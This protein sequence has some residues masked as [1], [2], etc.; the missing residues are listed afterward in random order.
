M[1]TPVDKN[2]PEL[3]EG[4]ALGPYRIEEIIFLEE[5]DAHLYKLIH[6]PTG[7]AH[8]HISHADTEN[9]FSVGFKTVPADST[10]V[11]HILEHTVLCGSKKYPVR[12]PFFSMLK[13]SLNTFMNAFTASDWTMYPFSTQNKKDFYN[14]MDVYLDA[15]FFPRLDELS[16]KQEGHR[17]EIA[18]DG[19]AGDFSLDYKGVVYN[20]MK[21]AMSSPYQVMTRSL[22][23]A[24][25]PDTT[26]RHNSGGDPAQ[27]VHLTHS[28]LKDFHQRHYHPSNARF[29]TYG[30]F[31]LEDHLRVIH[32]KALTDFEKINPDTDV[33]AQ[34]RWDRE[35]E[36]I[37]AYPLSKTENPEKK[38]QV[39]MAW[40]TADILDA[41]E[42]LSLVLLEQILL[43][44][45]AS[46]LRK[47]LIDSG[48]GTALSDASGY[49]R[50]NRDTMFACG[51][52]DT[53]KS[54]A[55]DINALIFKTLEHL[56]ANGI[57]KELIDSAIHQIEFHRKEVTNTPYPY[58]IRL[59]LTFCG[60]WFHGADP[61]RLL[62]FEEDIAKIREMAACGRFFETLIQK[63]LLDNP[64]RVFFILS[65]D[66][67]MEEQEARRVSGELD[68]IKA[69]LTFAEKEKIKKD[70]ESLEQLQNAHEDPACLPTLALSDIPPEI[71]R[72]AEKP[73]GP[74]STYCRPTSG[75][76]Y[77]SSLFETR[78]VQ[79]ELLPLIPI[80]AGVF[81]KAGT[82][83]HNY[84]EMARLIDAHTGG[85]GMSSHARTH[86]QT[87][88]C[89]PFA[90]LNGKCL[91]RNGEKLFELIGELIYEFDPTDVNRI[92]TLVL[93]FR[94]GMESA[95][96]QNG[97]RFAMML[98]SRNF[99]TARFLEEM[100]HGIHQL[101]T[102]KNITGS[103]DEDGPDALCARLAQIGKAVL[104][105]NHYHAA[106]IGEESSLAGFGSS[107]AAMGSGLKPATVGDDGFAGLCPPGRYQ[108]EGWAAASAVSFVSTSFAAAR[109]RHE[110][111]PVLFVVS[112]LLRS[113]YLHKEI[114]EKGGAYG[115][116]AAYNPEDG[117]FSM[118]SYR[119]PHITATLK[120]FDGAGDFLKN[121]RFDEEDIKE[122]ILQC[123]SEIDRPDSPG[124]AAQKAFNRKII[125]LSDEQ[126]L[127]FK[128]G[129]LSIAGS[130]VKEIG[131]KY[132]NPNI[133][134]RTKAV[135]S[136]EAQLEAAVKN[137]EH[138]LEIRKI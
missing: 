2:N 69:G 71:S 35:Q 122:A 24:L 3:K 59:L 94:A 22:M 134:P 126:R 96:I 1:N 84:V 41:F 68:Q 85:I 8:V 99:S 131:E 30:S 106:L 49:D 81:S 97:H 60:T 6:V 117:I 100:W 98:S 89:I 124:E 87:E 12:D 121:G 73:I 101:T 36:A 67:D 112:K 74:L 86:H 108:A 42:V 27:I 21:G 44:N 76:L 61:A 66:P 107:A 102:L 11:A 88:T 82:Q 138:P 92:K 29:Y 13:R 132:F 23:N 25:Y 65:P 115:G 33:P 79:R 111:G 45:A 127:N 135:I 38:Y 52:K 47:A 56:C 14:L 46:P 93:Q 70:Q 137:M 34:P 20:E 78:Q 28:A 50:D 55:A 54:S 123:C 16:F 105:Q 116:F 62:C 64:H 9:A 136:G 17:L 75:I 113:L 103:F 7:A 77:F 48:L 125:G 57:E 43:G 18:G 114:R 32:D 72:V 51:L 31:P 130:R 95:I 39:C 133:N 4:L 118:A 83:K 53:A 63:H 119:D 128:E 129:L 58:G 109:G 26:Y 91:N 104:V 80:F 5:L 10:G 120:V 37:F 15:V 110:D 40:L 19:I 90:A